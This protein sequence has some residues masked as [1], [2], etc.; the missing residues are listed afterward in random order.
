M[1]NAPRWSINDIVYLRESAAIGFIE[2]YR[3]TNI[4]FDPSYNR[5]LY[6][7]AIKHRG[8]EPNTVIDLHNLR[9]SEVLTL[10]ENDLVSQTEAL[11]IAIANTEQRLNYLKNKRAILE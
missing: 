9:R 10:A 8:T 1:S 4:K 5:W 3:I 2:G 7:A 11:D 6:E